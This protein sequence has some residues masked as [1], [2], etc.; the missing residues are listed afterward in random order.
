MHAHAHTHNT[1]VKYNL[2][3]SD[4]PA[5]KETFHAEF[6]LTG[7]EI[8]YTSGDAL[9]IYP[10][11]NP[12][13]VQAV[14]DALHVQGPEVPVPVPQ[15]C[16]SPLPEGDTMPLGRALRDYY[17]LKTVKPDLIKT[18]VGSVSDP[19]QKGAG[20]KLLKNGVSEKLPYYSPVF[21]LSVLLVVIQ[22]ESGFAN[23]SLRA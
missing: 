2:T 3:S 10:L 13:E 15:S 7:S 6:D 12:P 22:A 9:G 21:S 1:Q 20:E 4:A 11:N 17:D 14:L 23:L 8:T 18:L 19:Q 5:D 16:Y